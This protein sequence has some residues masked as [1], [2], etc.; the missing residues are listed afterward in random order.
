MY[1]TNTPSWLEF[2]PA[3]VEGKLISAPERGDLPF[4]VARRR[5]VRRLHVSSSGEA[6]PTTLENAIGVRLA[7]TARGPRDGPGSGS[8]STAHWSC[9]GQQSRKT[10][11]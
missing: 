11:V 6:E 4:D 3:K 1:N 2:D 7:G 9:H 10:V 8:V 5:D